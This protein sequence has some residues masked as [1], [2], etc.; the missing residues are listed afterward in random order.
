MECKNDNCQLNNQAVENFA[1]RLIESILPSSFQSHFCLA[2]GCFKSLIHN[3]MPN[4]IDLWPTSKE[5][6]LILIK[7]LISNGGVIE[8]EGEFNTVIKL[9]SSNNEDIADRNLENFV[10]ESQLQSQH[11]VNTSR[12][13]RKCRDVKGL[14]SEMLMV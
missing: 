9:T 2:G 4:D 1:I 8:H 11:L 13:P 12:V 10:N 5:D 3:K 7:E 6:R 14:E